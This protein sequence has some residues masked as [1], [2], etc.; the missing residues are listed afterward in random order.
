[1]EPPHCRAE[2]AT[3][4]LA[5]WAAIA[6]ARADKVRPHM[7]LQHIRY[8]ARTLRFAK[9]ELRF[10]EAIESRMQN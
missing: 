3:L 4:K 1:L 10:T 7:A 6:L 2:T 9:I 8:A 5:A